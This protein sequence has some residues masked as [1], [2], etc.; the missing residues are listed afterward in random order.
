MSAFND[1]CLVCENLL[2][3]PSAYCSDS[4][5]ELDQINQY[6]HHSMV[7]E[8]PL[9]AAAVPST[10]GSSVYNSYSLHSPLLVLSSTPRHSYEMEDDLNNDHFDLNSTD[11]KMNY[12]FNPTTTQSASNNSNILS[13]SMNY[14]KWLNTSARF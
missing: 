13:A 4:C 14:R 5:K 1:Y 11:Y 6:S 12:Y 10:S 7:H 3:T 8:S 2:S 9:L